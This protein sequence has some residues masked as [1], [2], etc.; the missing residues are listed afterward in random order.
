[1]KLN[2]LWAAAGKTLAAVVGITILTV[3][4]TAFAASQYTTIYTFS[5]DV[6]I[7]AG[8]IADPAGNLYGTTVRGGLHGYGTVFMLSS[9]PDG[10]WNR[11]VLHNFGGGRDGAYPTAP[12]IIDQSGNLYGTTAYGG[13]GPCLLNGY[14]G[15]GVVFK[16]TVNPNGSWKETVLHSFKGVPDGFYPARDGLT[17]GEAGAL[18]GATQFGGTVSTNCPNGCGTV[19]K[20]QPNADG[21]WHESVLHRFDEANGWS[22]VG[23]LIFDSTGNIY[24]LTNMGGGYLGPNCTGYPGCGTVFEL[25]PKPDGSWTEQILHFFAGEEMGDGGIAYIGMIFGPDGALYGTT[26]WG[27]PPGVGGVFRLTSQSGGSWSYEW[28]YSFHSG[29][30]GAV[31]WGRLTLDAAG[32]MYG[33]TLE[34]G[35][36]PCT[37]YAGGCGTIF[38]VTTDGVVTV[39]H[40]FRNRP[41]AYPHSGLALDPSGNFFGTTTGDGTSTFGT[42]FEITP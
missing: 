3:S 10:S 38:K 19:F 30:D 17:F 7:Y 14:A 1:M 12:L 37:N 6:P 22:P 9:N 23:G 40:E 15:C 31:P 29:K 21:S 35:R 34:G 32:N 27:A 5:A 4:A 13:K 28:F 36:G 39:L 24:G 11:R 26:A 20:L 41:G 18:Y 8:L 25:S 33:T 16:L 2:R 42:L